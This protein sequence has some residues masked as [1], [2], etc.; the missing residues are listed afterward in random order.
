MHNLTKRILL[1]TFLSDGVHLVKSQNI[2]CKLWYCIPQTLTVTTFIKWQGLQG[3]HLYLY[4]T[5]VS[6]FC[7]N[8]A[9][10]QITKEN[11]WASVVSFPLPQAGNSKRQPVIQE[12]CLLTD[13][14]KFFSCA[15]PF[16]LGA[17]E[18]KPQPIHSSSI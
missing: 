9:K 3:L 12:T 6:P 18:S 17:S 15:K 11:E 10:N 13:F 5:L 7:I 4:N 14:A 16:P 1:F 2:K 8:P